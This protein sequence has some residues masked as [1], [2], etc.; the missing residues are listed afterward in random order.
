MLGGIA[1]GLA[2]GLAAKMKK[3]KTV[4]SLLAKVGKELTKAEAELKGYRGRGAWAPELTVVVDALKRVHDVPKDASDSGSTSSCGYYVRVRSAAAAA[5]T[6]LD[7]A[8]AASTAA[9][10]ECQRSMLV[11]TQDIE[12][13][14]RRKV[15]APNRE[16]VEADRERAW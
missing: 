2:G 5:A 8:E 10:G 14:A 11:M 13:W 15:E 7:S 16:A 1:G 4:A 6:A 12:K 3:K 9:E